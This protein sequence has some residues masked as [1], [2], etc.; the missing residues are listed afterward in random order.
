[1]HVLFAIGLNVDGVR[2][3]VI[4]GN[5]VGWSTIQEDEACVIRHEGCD[6]AL[7]ILLANSVLKRLLATVVVDISQVVGLESTGSW[8]LH[9][10]EQGETTGVST[11]VWNVEVVW[12]TSLSDLLVSFPKLGETCSLDG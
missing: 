2:R 7:G 5:G 10:V 1:V 12:L 6:V 3:I 8:D 4:L 9:G 11:L